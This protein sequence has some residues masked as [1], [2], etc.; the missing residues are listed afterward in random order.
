MCLYLSKRGST[1]YFR[2]IIPPELRASF[3]GAS[4]FMYSLRT[5]DR[6]EAKRRRSA[7]ALQ[8]DTKIDEARARLGLLGS[9]AHS[10]SRTDSREQLEPTSLQYLADMPHSSSRT[11]K[12]PTTLCTAILDSW[13]AERKPR[14]KTIDAY[15]RAAT[16]FCEIIEKPLSKVSRDDVLRFK[17][18]LIDRGFT[19]PN[20]R[21]YLSR[22]RALIQY[23]M[24]NGILSSNPASG[25]QIVILDKKKRKRRPFSLE[26]LRA[27]FSQD[28]FTKGSRPTG[29]KGEAAFWLPTLALLHGARLEELGQLRVRDVSPMSYV[30]DQGNLDSAPCL[31]ITED[32]EDGLWLKNEPSQR[33]VPIHPVAIELGREPINGI[34]ISSD[35]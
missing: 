13:A 14:G 26:D 30:D 19:A 33:V 6:G 2:R 1:Y 20:I 29:C 21:C 32:E 8:T 3:D 31:S 17:Q 12:R 9:K 5:K 15:R 23:A 28:V 34:P 22:V 24:D 11:K 18:V 27:I 16:M 25:V 35:F 7:A 4:E 10:D